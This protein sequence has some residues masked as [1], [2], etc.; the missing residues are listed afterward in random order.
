MLHGASHNAG[1]VCVKASETNETVA[2][3]ITDIC[4]IL[5]RHWKGCSTRVITGKHYR[6]KF[7]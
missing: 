7:F 3:K 2:M 4:A 1:T 6:F 5:E